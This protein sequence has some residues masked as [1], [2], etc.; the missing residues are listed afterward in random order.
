MLTGSL[1]TIRRHIATPWRTSTTRSN[2]LTRPILPDMIFLQQTRPLPINNHRLAIDPIRYYSAPSTVSRNL[3]ILALASLLTGCTADFYENQADREVTQIVKDRE[4]RTLGYEPA[5]Q[6]QTQPDDYKAPAPAFNKIPASPIVR[7]AQSSV[8]PLR[9]ELVYSPLGP[10]RGIWIGPHESNTRAAA[11]Y[12]TLDER[13]RGRLRLGP[14]SLGERPARLDFFQSLQYAVENSRTYQDQMEDLYLSALNVTLQRHLFEPRPFAGASLLYQGG[15]KDVSYRSALTSTL[16]AGVRQRLPY[17][18]EVVAQGL[19]DFVNALDK[20]ASSGE[21][22]SLVLTASVPLLRGA[23]MVNL[24]PLINGERQMVYQVRTFENFRRDLVI[25]IAQQYFRLINL[26]QAVLDRRLNYAQFV[27]LAERAR[28]LYSAGRVAY[29]ELQRVLQDVLTAENSLLNSQE[30]FYSALDDYKLLLG[31]PTDQNLEIVPVELDVTLP[32]VNEDQ[33]ISLAVK[34]R[35]DL[36][37]ARDIVND[38]RRRVEN[39][40]NGLLPDLNITA[41]GQWGN[42]ADSPAVSIDERTNTYSARVDLDLPVDRVAERNQYRQALINVRRA[43]RDEEQLRDAIVA[44]VR[45]SIRLIRQSQITLEIQQQ[46]VELA[47]KRRENAYELLRSGKSA[48]TRDLTEAQNSLLNA[49]DAYE[50]AKATLQINVLRFLRNSGTLRLDPAAGAVG[51]A[52]DRLA[53]NSN[54]ASPMR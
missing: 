2:R 25:Q 5:V 45:E 30:A 29:I 43:A 48:S 1:A 4:K 27:Q 37:T 42:S 10:R 8:Q 3:A 46:A 28:A 9:V 24:E 14:P 16:R 47:Q 22:A 26:Q 53:E 38:T 54:T 15:Q 40:R 12:E 19:V 11:G 21:D 13:I 35:L 39:A 17:G 7:D 33:A 41:Q 34:Y 36:Q 18:G 23:G 31:M 51:H 50:N 49:R 32:K 52:M 6:A 44:D 20:N